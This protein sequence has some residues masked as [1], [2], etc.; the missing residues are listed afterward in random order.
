MNHM[1]WVCI[2]L[3]AGGCGGAGSGDP[4]T[5]GA[6]AI[7]VIEGPAPT[8][9][10]GGA[11]VYVRGA[12]GSSAQADTDAGGVARLQLA[13]GAAPWSVTAVRR[14]FG[15]VSVVGVRGSLDGALRL[16]PVAAP[17]YGAL[18]AVRGAITGTQP[19]ADVQ[20][21]A[22]NFETVSHARGAFNSRFYVSG[23]DLPLALVGLEFD[24]R[25]DLVN[26]AS[27]A[28]LA[29]G[30]S[31]LVVDL[32][33]PATPPPVTRATTLVSLPGRGA[34]TSALDVRL[35]TGAQRLSR[36]SHE[37]AWVLVGTG[38][39]QGRTS[40]GVRFEFQTL[41]GE[42]APDVAYAQLVDGSQRAIVNVAFH[43]LA[44]EGS[45]AI[46][47]VDALDVVGAALGDA[48][49]SARGEG[50]DAYQLS[51]R[52]PGAEAPAWRVYT[53]DCTPA[54]RVAFPDLPPGWSP[55][56]IGL[57]GEVFAL[58][59]AIKMRRGAPRPWETRALNSALPEYD[60]TVGGVTT[61]LAATWR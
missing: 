30:T 14:G 18:V 57:S 26:A 19:G 33:F 15:A 17:D 52:G 20:V 4:T 56:T 23:G 32:M 1:R 27:S 44:T 34:L 29:R 28:P 10:S 41:G 55:A 59:M 39:A 42:L 31:P 40:E 25:G 11:T 50:C 47:A 9:A 61:R 5:P 60:Y 46:G 53:T 24:A 7:R 6:V 58:A 38:R 45:L 8:P 54:D 21:D 51:A 2:G 13:A 16:D 37:E 35:V 12:D 43:G 49:M 3:M 36:G 48:A 22:M